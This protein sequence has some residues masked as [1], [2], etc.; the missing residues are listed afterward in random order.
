L[1]L[2]LINIIQAWEQKPLVPEDSF[3]SAL[4]QVDDIFDDIFRDDLF[5][6]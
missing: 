6:D 4:S 2:F 1:Q 5:A 3:Y